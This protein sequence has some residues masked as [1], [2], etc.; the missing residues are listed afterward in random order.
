M[1]LLVLL[2]GCP[3]ATP[4]PTE[5]PATVAPI[6]RVD[7]GPD[8][9][10]L[11]PS[12]GFGTVRIPFD[13]SRDITAGASIGPELELEVR[14]GIR[15]LAITVDDADQDTG[16]AFL[17][18]R[19]E[20]LIDFELAGEEPGAWV[21]PPFIHF[22]A[23]GGTI[24]MPM[25]AGSDPA[26][27][28]CLRVRPIELGVTSISGTLW[29]IGRNGPADGLTAIDLNVVTVG[30]TVISED[31]VDLMV[32]RVDAIWSA[33]NGPGVGTVEIYN[34][35]GNHFPT[36][37]ELNGIRRTVVDNTRLSAVNVFLVQDLMRPGVLGEAGGI[38]GP[39]GLQGVDAAGVIAT[40]DGHSTAD[41][42]LVAQ[43]LG[44]TV[45]H[46]VGHHL[47]LF[48]TT[49]SDGFRYESLN[50]TPEC[51][52]TADTNADGLLSAQECSAFDGS[53]F[54]FWVADQLPQSTMSDEQAFIMNH[55]PVAV[56]L[57]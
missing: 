7:C 36:D 31:A 57:P 56:P 20:T 25:G 5:E 30:D 9:R 41:G 23:L 34:V 52:T 14:E 19:G 4:T 44:G 17:S 13:W 55:S 21:S 39:L 24:S 37:D 26:G 22:P 49:E 48:H 47:G 50:D 8:A 2:F 16:F 45:A 43:Q 32:E 1:N 27:G 35:P 53:N 10:V 29:V 11:G 42:F 54:M 18:Y 6:T 15:G 46:E 28:G 40:I 12:D 3:P 38:A 33:A 51:P